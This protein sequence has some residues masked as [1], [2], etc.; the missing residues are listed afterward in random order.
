M[1]SDSMATATHSGSRSSKDGPAPFLCRPQS[2]PLSTTYF[3]TQLG[4]ECSKQSSGPTLFVL[5]LLAPKPLLRAL[6]TSCLWKGLAACCKCELRLR[7]SANGLAQICFL[8]GD[9]VKAG[10]GRRKLHFMTVMDR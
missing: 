3:A 9:D 10:P 6:Q 8:C 7:A 5:L 2:M 4:N 1:N